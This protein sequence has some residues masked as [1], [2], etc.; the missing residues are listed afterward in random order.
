MESIED[1]LNVN[2]EA[3][4]IVHDEDDALLIVDGDDV[5][6]LLLPRLLENERPHP[7]AVD[8]LVRTRVHVRKLSHDI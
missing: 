6:R 7:R 4:S 1:M 2:V 3:C 5:A 8:L